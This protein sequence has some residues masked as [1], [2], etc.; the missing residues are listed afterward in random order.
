MEIEYTKNFVW[1]KVIDATTTFITVHAWGWVG[2]SGII[3]WYWQEVCWTFQ[4]T[5]SWW[6]WNP[7]R[8]TTRTK[9]RALTLRLNCLSAMATCF[10]L[11]KLK[12]ALD[13]F[14]N[15]FLARTLLCT[16]FEQVT[17]QLLCAHIFWHKTV[18]FSLLNRLTFHQLN[19]VRK[20]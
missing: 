20:N 1:M 7:E 5:S 9:S 8:E 12:Q 6:E 2:E 18:A 11:L 17:L 13:H 15:L 10:H 3:K 16:H 19:S 14:L 4:Q